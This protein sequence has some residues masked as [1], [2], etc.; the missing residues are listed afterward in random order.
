M[1]NILS[2]AVRLAQLSLAFKK[3]ALDW[4]MGYVG[5]H[6]IATIDEIKTTLKQLF[7]RPKSYSQ[8]VNELKY[9][10]QGS[11]E[12]IWEANQRLKKVIREGEFQYDDRQHT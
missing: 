5:Q 12:S 6:A 3:R 2:D 7:K 9:I 8:I 1:Q 4:Y 11:S 10:K